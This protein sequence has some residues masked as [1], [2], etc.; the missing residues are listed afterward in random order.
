VLAIRE[1][2]LGPDHPNTNRV[3]RNFATLLLARASTGEAL[4][5]AKMA[6]AAREKALAATT[7]E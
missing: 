3:G 1:N 6:L 2:F 7:S 4:A 5:L